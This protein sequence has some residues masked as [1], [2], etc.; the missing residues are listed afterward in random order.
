MVDHATVKVEKLV[1]LYM[2]ICLKLILLTGAHAYT[3]IL[4]HKLFLTHI[5]YLEAAV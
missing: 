1:H 2:H 4:P 5:T 3:R